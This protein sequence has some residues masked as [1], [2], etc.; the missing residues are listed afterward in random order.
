MQW[1]RQALNL[2]TQVEPYLQSYK[3][4]RVQLI[5]KNYVLLTPRNGKY[6]AALRAMRAAFE[7]EVLRIR[8]G[9]RPNSLHDPVIPSTEQRKS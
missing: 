8:V 1:N 4:L 6:T 2:L 3:R 9:A 5:L 7:A